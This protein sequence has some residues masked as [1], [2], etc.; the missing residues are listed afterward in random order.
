M[1]EGVTRD[2]VYEKFLVMKIDTGGYRPQ[3]TWI[4]PLTVSNNLRSLSSKSLKHLYLAI[5][6]LGSLSRG[7]GEEEKA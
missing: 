7:R 5:R 1:I 6:D 4:S 3:V 2:E